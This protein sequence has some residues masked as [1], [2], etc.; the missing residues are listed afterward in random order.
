MMVEPVSHAGDRWR[1]PLDEAGW[2][3]APGRSRRLTPGDPVVL[4]HCWN[5]AEEYRPGVDVRRGWATYQLEF[6]LPE[7][8]S[9]KE[10]RL[11]CGGFHGIGQAWL[12]GRSIGRF[13]GDFIGFDLPAT[14]SLRPGANHLIVQVG[15]VF[16]RTILPGLARP[17]FHLYGGLGGGMQLVALPPVRL[18][19]QDS[20]VISDASR[21]GELTV[22]LA[23]VNCGATAEVVAGHVVIRNSAG[24]T[25]AEAHG[26]DIVLPPGAAERQ[27]IR[28]SIPE[29]QLWSPESPVLYEIDATLRRAE[30]IL[31]RRAWTFGLRTI[32][33]DR[34]Q[35]LLING[36]PVTLRGIN[37]HENWPG[38][39]FAMPAVLHEADARHI[40]DMGLNFVRLSHYPQSPHFL[41][42]CD[43][44]GILVLAELCSWKRIRGGRWLSAAAT[45]LERMIRRDRHHPSVILW[46]L[47]NEGRHRAAYQRLHALAHSLDG[48]RPTIYAENHARRARRKKTLGVTD[49]WGLNY[50]FDELDFARAAAPTGCVLATECANLPYARRGHYPAEAQQLA[51]IRD[52]VQRM[53]SAGP[54][55]IGW[56]LWGFADYATPRRQRWF[57]ECG[58]LDG[59]RD[60]K[61]AADWLQARGRPHEPF[62]SVRGDWSRSAGHLRRLYIVTNCPELH[63]VR[64]DGTREILA[65][66]KPELLEKDVVFANAPLRLE[67][68]H[69]AGLVAADL[70][71]WGAP[72][73]FDLQAVLVAE[74]GNAACPLYRCTLQVRDAQGAAVLAYEGDAIIPLPS[75]CRSALI[76]GERLPV[77]GG[78]AAFFIELPREAADI[79]VECRLDDFPPQTLRLRGGGTP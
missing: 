5:A 47:G 46:G 65:L 50:E 61:L 15:N 54:G 32:R 16:S 56:T 6:D 34:H 79:T 36:A 1:L 23:L 52:A 57:R 55:A 7:M 22:D 31:D 42:A 78:H 10:W 66:S 19:R 77:H 9:A 75:G 14:P 62:L 43:R 33:C 70:D 49:V 59:A 18:V 53:E 76:G 24:D 44:Q 26:P 35:G 67:G 3:W 41:D 48:S 21:P 38:F 58:V 8:D 71:P 39:G 29:P 63:L 68:H 45:Q 2:R 4:P 73:A 30:R 28:C 69:P 11:R 25:V 40:R 13:N 17:D 37:R 64:A 60:R 74:P 51:V 12:N 20:Q 72:A 27:S